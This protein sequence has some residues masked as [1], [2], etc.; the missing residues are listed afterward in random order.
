MRWWWFWF[1]ESLLLVL[2]THPVVSISRIVVGVMYCFED[3][4]FQLENQRYMPWRN[5]MSWSLSLCII[6]RTTSRTQLIYGFFFLL[7]SIRSFE[8]GLGICFSCSVPKQFKPWVT[9]GFWKPYNKFNAVWKR[10]D[11]KHLTYFLLECH[12]KFWA[13]SRSR[14]STL[15]D[16]IASL[17]ITSIWIVMNDIRNSVKRG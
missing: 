17:V 5:N 3:A 4:L 8:K 9:Q 6:E 2:C 7:I 11:V 15:G 16:G 1:F 10:C 13:H 14:F 12:R